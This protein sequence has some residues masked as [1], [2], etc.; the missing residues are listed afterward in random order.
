MDNASQGDEEVHVKV[1]KS[2]TK[3]PR[4]IIFAT[5]SILL[6]MTVLILVFGYPFL[7]GKY[8]KNKRT[9]RDDTEYD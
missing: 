5:S 9:V 1:A 3:L 8:F 7:E 2:K 6:A 4:I